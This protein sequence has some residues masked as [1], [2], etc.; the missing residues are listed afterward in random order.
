MYQFLPRE[1]PEH[2]FALPAV[3]LSSPASFSPPAGKKNTITITVPC[4]AVL[5]CRQKTKASIDLDLQRTAS[6][7][8][9]PSSTDNRSIQMLKIFFPIRPKA[10][11]YLCV[12]QASCS[13]KCLLNCLCF[14]S[15]SLIAVILLWVSGDLCS[16]VL[17][18]Q[19]VDDFCVALQCGMDQSTLAIL[20]S[21]SH[22]AWWRGHTKKDLQRW[23]WLGPGNKLAYIRWVCVILL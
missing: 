1:S 14:P 23:F 20:I 9:S 19:D 15:H 6:N 11:A 16:P 3:H 17:D 13:R 22:L 21:M 2:P 7:E 10:D 12:S 4:I 8:V 18:Q 5:L